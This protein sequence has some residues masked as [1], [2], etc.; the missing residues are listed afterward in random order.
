MDPDVREKLEQSVIVPQTEYNGKIAD[1]K[2]DP[3]WANLEEVLRQ[4]TVVH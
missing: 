1:S 2:Y 4:D 3:F